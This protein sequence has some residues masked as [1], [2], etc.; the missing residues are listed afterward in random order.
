MNLNLNLIAIIVSVVTLFFMLYGFFGRSERLKKIFNDVLHL[1]LFLIVG[2][3]L[4]SIYR[5]IL[6]P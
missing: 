2:Y 3:M 1:F 5:S 4:F 6:N